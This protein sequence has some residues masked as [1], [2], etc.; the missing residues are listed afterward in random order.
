[1]IPS[2]ES[3]DA[4]WLTEQLQTAGHDTKVQSFT[5][6]KIGT[7][8]IG[9]CIRYRL[10]CTGDIKN[11]PTSLVGKFPST[12]P[13]SRSTGVSLRN[14]IKEVSFYR[15]MARH[16]SINTPR[17]YFAEIEGEGPEFML[18]LEDLA[19]AR[20]GDQL[21]GCSVDVAR[22][23]VMELVGL[24]APMWND[25]SL[26]DL[27]FLK[28]PPEEPGAFKAL[29]MMLLT[30]FLGRY[31]EHLSPPQQDILTR[32]GEGLD[33]FRAAPS[34]VFSPIHIDYRLDNIMIDD[35]GEPPIITVVDWQSVTTGNPITDVG[36]F[37]GSGLLPEVRRE[38][39]EEIVRGYHDGLLSTGITGYDFNE[40][41]QDY[42]R[43]AFAGFTVAVIASMLVE[44]TPRGDEMF[45][46][47]TSRHTQHAIDLGADEFLEG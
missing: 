18:L 20:Q 12:D 44:Q 43:A 39:E 19:P 8:Q 6:E 27:P 11:V 17:C 46:A 36:Y 35:R 28:G 4:A 23:A 21:T 25:E 34:S 9:L 7:G 29:Y 1:M 45:I 26:N 2:P 40:C 32:F 37:L 31:G 13:Q 24:H 15:E 14:Y 3:I 16:V 38:V 30:G 41:W 42:R 47:M 22:A 5:A 10:T 33:A